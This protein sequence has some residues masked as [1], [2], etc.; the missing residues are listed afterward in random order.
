[1]TR[2]I[3]PESVRVLV[4]TAGLALF[5]LAVYGLTR[6]VSRAAG[7]D[8]PG[9]PVWLAATALVAVVAP[10]TRRR[11]QRLADRVAYGREG[12]PHAVMTRFLHRLADTLAVD[13]VLPDLAR[14]AS[15]AV[16]SPG[17]EVRLWLV[18]GGEWRQ[19]WPPGQDEVGGGVSLALRHSGDPVGNLRVDLDADQLS[20]ADRELLNRLAGPA[21]LAL[22][23]VRL[24]YELRRRLHEANE[25][26]EQLRRSRQRLIEARG[27]QRRRF[28][29]AVDAQVH[30]HLAAADAALAARPSLVDV[31]AAESLAALEALRDLAVGV[32]PP[33]LGERGLDDAI[34]R[35]LGSL[36]TPV[37]LR[38]SGLD[39][40]RLPPLV[41]A[42][43]YFCCVAMVEDLVCHGPAAVEL[44]RRGDTLNMTVRSAMSTPCLPTPDTEQLIRD[45]VDAV[46]GEVDVRCTARERFVALTLPDGNPPV[47]GGSPPAI[48][49]GGRA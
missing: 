5:V 38:S 34:D 10:V 47:L 49:A 27:V 9:T 31:A 1:V 8:H 45:R 29:A 42:A 15:Q 23:N 16:H 25:L 22:S 44:T 6:V 37:T 17:S 26:A 19:T 40:T 18:D 4:L 21:G 2:R 43:A 33:V 14:T 48:G 36:T 41:E 28:T 39:G 12:D 20:A 24:T 30:R 46:G 32:F 35:Y 3:P 7:I 11:W 13:D